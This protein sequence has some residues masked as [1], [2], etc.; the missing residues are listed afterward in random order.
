M[1][2]PTAT[3]PPTPSSTSAPE[4]TSATEAPEWDETVTFSVTWD[5]GTNSS[6]HVEI[7]VEKCQGIVIELV[8][9]EPVELKFLDVGTKPTPELWSDPPG[10]VYDEY[11]GIVV[12]EAKASGIWTLAVNGDRNT[13]T[14]ANV[15]VS[16]VATFPWSE[17]TGYITTC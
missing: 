5:R 14:T 10:R 4:A 9:S 16:Y 3:A 13:G 1:P 8:S 12:L 15:T 11:E 6:H 2:A 7:P 17:A